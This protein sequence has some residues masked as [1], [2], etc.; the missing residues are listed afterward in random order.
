MGAV[1]SRETTH[2]SSLSPDRHPSWYAASTTNKRPRKDLLWPRTL[3]HSTRPS[4]SRTLKGMPRTLQ[5][6]TLPSG[7]RTLKETPRTL[8]HS[9]LPSGSRT[10]KGMPRTL[11]HSTLPSGSRTLKETPRTLRLRARNAASTRP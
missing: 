2:R 9:T 1:T 7:S 11:Q 6:S 3:Q 8:Q 4:G 5:H 10:L